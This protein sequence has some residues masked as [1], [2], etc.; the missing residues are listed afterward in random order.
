[1]KITR[2]A[3]SAAASAATLALAAGTPAAF[4]QD[5]TSVRIGYVVSQTGPNATGAGTT[6]I[7]N[8]E[9]WVHDVNA[10]GGLKL[11]N[12]TQLPIEVTVYDDRSQTEEV[13]RGIERLA[14]QDKVD[15]ILAPWGTGFNLA[16]APLMARFGYPQL[17]G[18]SVVPNIPDIHE[19]WPTSFWLLGNAPGYADSL[20]GVLKAQVDAGV[21]NNKVAMLAIADGFGI[22]LS[23]ATRQSLDAAGFELVIDKTYPLGTQDFS[24]L[25][26][27]AAASGA[28]SFVAFS[29]PGDTFAITKQAQL[30]KYNPTV[31]YT[32]V[33]TNFPVYPQINE[34]NI[35]GVMSLGGL[36]PD[37]PAIKDYLARH[38]A[39]LGTSPDAWAS[40]VIYASLQMLAQAIERRGLDRK[41]VTEE[42]ANGSFETILGTI[43]LENNGYRD[44]WYTGQWQNGAFVAVGPIDKPGAA[45]AV[46]PKP[47]WK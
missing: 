46:V 17:A 23:E 37:S 1:M 29:Y 11:P 30:S 16:V 20:A 10:A 35:D 7:P 3:F 14:N 42:I 24:V 6:T 32:G 18:T 33:G 38:E 13:V 15:F 43:K 22:E 26:S 4:A 19:R 45:P 9:L 12:G 36:N 28:D 34:G 41:A 47:D 2:R 27:E 40:P 5:R 8:Y 25:L 44:M 21:I 39:V 31:F